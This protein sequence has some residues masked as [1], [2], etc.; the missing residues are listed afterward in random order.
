MEFTYLVFTPMPGES[1]GKQ[2]RS[3]LVCSRDVF[4]ALINEV[5]TFEQKTKSVS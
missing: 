3:L 2:Y 4:R 1:Y 5:L